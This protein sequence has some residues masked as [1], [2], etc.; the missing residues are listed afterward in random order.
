MTKDIK[1]SAF[2]YALLKKKKKKRRKVLG[3]SQ[4]SRVSTPNFPEKLTA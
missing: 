4:G 1:A 3:L 2:M